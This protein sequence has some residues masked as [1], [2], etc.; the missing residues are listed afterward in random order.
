MKNVYFSILIIS[1]FIIINLSCGQNPSKSSANVYIENLWKSIIF[2]C[3]GS[4]YIVSKDLHQIIEIKNYSISIDKYD[5]SKADELN[6]IEWI[7]SSELNFE[8]YR[9]KYLNNPHGPWSEWRSDAS[10]NGRVRVYLKKKNGIW[11]YE[12]GPLGLFG[13]VYNFE[14]SANFDCAKIRQYIQ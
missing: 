8:V 2:N 3:D 13:Y 9:Y 5:M 11:S 1:I 10:P 4:S 12:N 7:G 14:T 6:G